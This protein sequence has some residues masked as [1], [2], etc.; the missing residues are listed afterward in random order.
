MKEETKQ[1]FAL[2]IIYYSDIYLLLLINKQ[3]Y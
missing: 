1:K 3:T 2:Y